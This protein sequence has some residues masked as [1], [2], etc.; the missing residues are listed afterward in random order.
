M[1]KVQGAHVVKESDVMIKI[2]ACCTV[3]ML[4]KLEI[5]YVFDSRC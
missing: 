1:Q 5:D 3:R 4:K 2:N